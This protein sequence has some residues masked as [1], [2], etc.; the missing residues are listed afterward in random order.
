MKLYIGENLK[1]LREEKKVTQDTL[2]EYLGGTYQAVSR[3]ENGLAYPDI[4]LL[5]EIARFFEVSLEELMGTES[6][7]QKIRSFLNDCYGLRQTDKPSVLAKLRELER[8]YPNDWEIKA[9][10]CETLIDPR[11][12]S[13]DEILP[14]LRR[15]AFAAKEK[16]TLKDMWAFK[17]IAKAMIM[18]VPEEEVDEWTEYLPAYPSPNYYAVLQDRYRERNQPK[19]SK[20]YGSEMLL[21][22]VGFLECQFP[23]FDHSPEGNIYSFRI[24]LRLMDAIVGIPYCDENGIVHNSLLLFDRAA[25]QTK[26]ASGYTGSGQIEQ[27]LLE[28]EKGVDLWLLYSEAVK[29]DFFTSDYPYLEPQKNEE[30]D[31]FEGINW[32]IGALTA[33]HGWEW[34]DPVR[35]DERFQNQLRRLYEK[36]AELTE[37]WKDR[38]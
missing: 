8:E 12:T 4:E 9:T 21:S 11:P 10:I 13:Y 18:A 27:G 29:N 28:L 24:S 35:K 15:Y 36:Q 26:M 16:C 19:K 14:E 3:W 7:K 25:I 6:G 33:P 1:K 37:Y 31:K 38:P 34:L 22:F 32:I 2:A 20:H 17:R 23:N 30:E 5:P